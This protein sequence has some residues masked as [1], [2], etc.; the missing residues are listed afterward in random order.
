V[1][2]T[3]PKT[4]IDTFDPNFVWV[5]GRRFKR[6]QGGSPA[7]AA[8]PA[9]EEQRAESAAAPAI[10]FTSAAHEH[11]E[12]AFTLQA[13]PS[14]VSQQL[15]VPDIPAYGYIR[16]VL[17]EVTAAG[18]VLGPGVMHEDG[19]FNL[20]Q[21]IALVDTNG[22]PIF[23]PLDGYSTL[24]A[25]I[26]GGYAY[27]Q[28][29]RRSPWFS[30]GVNFKFFLRVPIEISHYNAL[31]CLSNQNAAGAYKLQLQLNPSTALFSTAPTTLPTV[32]IKAHL[33]AWSQPNDTDA[34]GRPQAQYPPAHGT[35]QFWS[36]RSGLPVVAGNN[37]IPLTRVGS[38]IRNLVF[39]C[40][41][42]AGARSD[43][44]FPDPVT[45]QWD[46]R[47]QWQESQNLRIQNMFEKIVNLSARDT[48]VFWWNFDHALQNRAGDGP[49]SLWLPTV[50]ATRLEIDGN[51]A[52]AGT[53]Q[54]LTNDISLAEVVAAE[55]Y[56]E[57]SR[58][59]FHP[60]VG[61]SNPNAQ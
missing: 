26:V 23:G 2:M 32:T 17:L 10:P 3:K 34:A 27:Q 46:A 11:T 53:M 21:N 30:N 59:G 22:A 42:A 9:Q 40:R 5:H 39:I 48:G 37:T 29:P 36:N 41:N 51:A 16:H 24:W 13:V 55:R 49:P 50:Q 58:T 12:P 56:V 33:E 38:L 4:G 54:I 6:I 60:E 8:P 15:N 44:A 57:T 18:G 47:A 52:V 19:P 31:G 1:L 35:A 43:S 45:L 61:V 20:F 14:A 25:N 7:V 28:D